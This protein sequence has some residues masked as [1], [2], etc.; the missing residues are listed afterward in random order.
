MSDFHL[1]SDWQVKKKKKKDKYHYAI[2][3]Q[4]HPKKN[5]Q[6]GNTQQHNMHTNRQKLRDRGKLPISK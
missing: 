6:L 1:Q 4:R 5:K 2:V 3:E